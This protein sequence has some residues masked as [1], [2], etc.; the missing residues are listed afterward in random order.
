LVSSPTHLIPL[1]HGFALWKWSCIRGAGFPA[2]WVTDLAASDLARGTEELLALE[3]ELSSARTEAISACADALEKADGDRRRALAKTMKRLRAGKVPED[4]DLGSTIERLRSADVAFEAQRTEISSIYEAATKFV[5]DALRRIAQDSRF[6]EALT[7]QNHRAVQGGLAYLLRRPS[8]ATDDETRKNERLVAS[9]VQRYCVK[10]DTIGFFGPIGWAQ[11]SREPPTIDLRPGAGL[12]RQRRVFFEY[13]SIAELAAKFAEDPELKSWLRPRVSPSMRLEGTTLHAPIDQTRVLPE[14]FA[15]V[16]RACDGR[17][18]ARDLAHRLATDLS[19]EL[20]DEDEVFEMLETLEQQG[21]IRWTLEVPTAD[22]QPE[23]RLKEAL[24]EIADARSSAGPL[25][26]LEQ[27]VAAKDE[28]A[29]AAGD[30]ERLSKAFGELEATFTRITGKSGVRRGGQTYAG[31]MLVYEDCVRDSD[32]VFGPR[33]YE[34]LAKPLA[35]LVSSARWYTHTIASRYR[36]RFDEIYAAL[37][38]ETG[39]PTISYPRFWSAV[40]PLFG[41]REAPVSQIVL[42][43]LADLHARWARILALPENVRQVSLASAEIEARVRDAFDAPCPGWPSA[44]NYSPDV[45][46][47]ARDTRAI[48]AGDFQMV[49]GELHL[50]ANTVLTPFYLLHHP[51]RDALI[52]ARDLELPDRAIEPVESAENASRADLYSV[53]DHDLHLEMGKTRSFRPRDHVVAIADLV[54]ERAGDRLIVRTLDGTHCFDV[55]VFFQQ[56]LTFATGPSFSLLPQS[57]HIPRVTID[58]FVIQRERW[59]FPPDAL[60]FAKLERAVDRFVGANRWVAAAGLPRYVF[61]KVPEEPK[62]CFVDFSSPPY[63]EILTKLAR[64][65]SRVTISEM[66]P[67][68]GDLWLR[69]RDDRRYTSEL[70]I[71]ITD[72][73]SWR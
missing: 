45:M 7:W 42:D 70:R 46:V 1:S 41:S 50:G 60:A 23:L 62:P 26:E 73:E 21:I 59:T 38:V 15:A 56:Y 57:T 12:V 29:R 67:A 11:F 33:F 69:D 61:V 20:Q 6:R 55:I 31:R 53:S 35:L 24:H 22:A 39:S 52:R 64:K 19:L 36:R 48:E 28:I 30:A 49:L 51:E 66:L 27:L 9:Y 40:G 10:N 3:R 14:A 68:L 13:W 72:P 32:L 17:T 37:S 65:A 4:M 5:G 54:V 34:K 2:S 25:G 8:G 18:R 16:L 71:A 63:V 47:A 44:R 58:D 43:V